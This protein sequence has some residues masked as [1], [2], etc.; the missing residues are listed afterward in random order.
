[1]LT[2]RKVLIGAA[3]AGVATFFREAND[4]LADASQPSTPVRFKVPPGACD[5]HTH[6]IGDPRR[7][8][9]APS[10]GYTPELAAV[11]EMRALHRALHI[12]RV[13]VVQPSFYGTDNSC[14]LDAVRRLGPGARGIV[15]I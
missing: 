15:V 14:T 11:E 7:F 6:I 1:M 5:C 3:A 12:E 13:V 9:F 10:R 4:A 2:R 8:P